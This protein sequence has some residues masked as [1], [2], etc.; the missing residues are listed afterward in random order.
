MCV[1][2]CVCQSVYVCVWCC[3]SVVCLLFKQCKSKWISVYTTLFI[4]QTS[5]CTYTSCIIIWRQ[6]A[7]LYGYIVLWEHRNCNALCRHGIYNS[8]ISW[9]LLLHFSERH[10][11]LIF[12]LH[13]DIN[14][15]LL[16]SFD[17]KADMCNMETKTHNQ[18]V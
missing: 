7:I 13:R 6:R 9:W 14:S 17:G 2:V 8:K 5:F 12:F 10:P 3:I 15:L 4:Y 1:C 18:T 11:L 16:L